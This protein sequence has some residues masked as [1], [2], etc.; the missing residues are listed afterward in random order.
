LAKRFATRFAPA[1]QVNCPKTD[2]NSKC[3]SYKHIQK[4]FVV[5]VFQQGIGDVGK[6][7][8]RWDASKKK[9]TFAFIGWIHL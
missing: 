3:D 6:K 8:P 4:G 1:V 2:A 5:T 7:K 9:K